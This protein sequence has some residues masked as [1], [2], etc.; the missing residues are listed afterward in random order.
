MDSF[1]YMY[2]IYTFLVWILNNCLANTFFALDP[3]NSTIKRLSC[4]IEKSDT[5]ML[6]TATDTQCVYVYG[7]G[8]GGGWGVWGADGRGSDGGV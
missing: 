1:L 7:E 5:H 2:V 8:G 3:S 6:F 4:I